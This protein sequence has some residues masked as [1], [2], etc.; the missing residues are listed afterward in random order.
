MNSENGNTLSAVP[1]A[2]EANDGVR[3]VD[4]EHVSTLAE[5]TVAAVRK[6]AHERE[7]EAQLADEGLCG[8][9]VDY[10]EPPPRKG[11][12][13]QTF[14]GV[15]FYPFDP[16]PEEIRIEDIAHALSM[17][18]RYA[19]HC[20]KFYSVAEHSIRVAELLPMP[21]KLW[22]LLHDAA[23][24]YLVDLPRPIKRHSEIGALYRVAEESL[25]RV[26]AERFGLSWPEPPEIDAADKALLCWEAMHLLPNNTW[27]E[28]WRHHLTGRERHLEFPEPPNVAE[29]VFLTAFEWLARY[30]QPLTA[31]PTETVR[32][33]DEAFHMDSRKGDS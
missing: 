7:A 10:V 25:M 21:L 11:D 6:F 22:G 2:S 26:I 3:A 17:Q 4:S 8:P 29:R 13:I 32:T 20:S 19:G 15:E 24:A 30:S 28:K 5:V 16:R 1:S 18:C 9:I 12:W 23:E 33:A 14:T 27:H 31:S